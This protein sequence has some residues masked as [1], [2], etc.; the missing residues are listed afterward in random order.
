VNLGQVTFDFDLGLAL[1]DLSDPGC[2]YEVG[3]AAAVNYKIACSLRIGS[4]SPT[5]SDYASVTIMNYAALVAGLS[6]VR[7]K[8]DIPVVYPMQIGVVP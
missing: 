7:I 5:A 2:A 1:A 8:F 4:T 3:F 6:G